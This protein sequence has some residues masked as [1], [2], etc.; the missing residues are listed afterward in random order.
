MVVAPQSNIILLKVPLTL[1]NKNQLTF[2]SK[3]AQFNYFNGLLKI[4]M[5]N[6]TY[7]RKDN[8]IYFDE[9]YDNLIQYNYLMYQ[10]ESYSDKWF[11]AFITNMNYENNQTTSIE[12]ITDVWQ[13]WQFDITFKQSFIEREM[14]SVSED[15][16][17]ANLLPEGLET[18]EYEVEG[19]AEIDDLEPWYIVAYAEDTFG[20]RYNGIY[21]GILFYAYSDSNALRGLITQLSLAGKTN[22]ILNIFTIPKLALYPL[23]QIAQKLE[24]DIKATPRPLTLISTPSSLDGYTPRNQKLRTYPYMY[25]AFNPNGGNGKIYRYE[26]F[27][28]GTPEF[29]I[30]SEINPNP[31]VCFIPQNYRGASGDS[32][33]DIATLNGYPSI[34]WAND[35]FNVWLS[36]NSE[37][38]KLQLEQEEQNVSLNQ[39]QNIGSMAS[40]IGSVASGNIGEGISTVSNSALNYVRNDINY[41]YYQK[42]QMAQIEKQKMLPNTGN[43]GSNNTTLLGYEM[44]DKNVFTRYTIKY[45]FAERI[46]KYFD[47]YGYL[48]N[49]V[50]LPNLNNRPNWNYVKTI[51]ANILGNIPQQDLN[52]IKNFFNNGI[53]LW[54]NPSTFLD[55]SQNNRT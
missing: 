54:H 6:A 11:Y 9:K 2:A 24:A 48:T 35:T 16:P 31:T 34:S 15:V 49:K 40:S 13:T 5:D 8:K 33:S 26:N 28:N 46:D 1:D 25:V 43:F 37:I 42:M 41:E 3:Q 22:F 14:L 38:I 19:T 30:I 7:V 21:S 27:T 10:N 32:L 55:Y 23:D 45:Q 50:K 44:F 4:E 53:T 47:M 29:K 52:S 36:Q 39:L 17:G 12:F 18:G 51:G 20:F